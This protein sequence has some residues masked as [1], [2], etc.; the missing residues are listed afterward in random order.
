MKPTKTAKSLGV[1]F[2]L[3]AFAL[4]SACSD[5]GPSQAEAPEQEAPEVTQEQET[6]AETQ[7]EELSGAELAFYN[8][9]T[10]QDQQITP[11]EAEANLGISSEFALIDLDSDGGINLSEFMDY[12]GEATAAGAEAESTEETVEQATE[13]LQPAEGEEQ[14]TQ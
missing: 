13:E 11:D 7:N 1:L 12:A 10:N 14:Q 9:D 8:L 6:A 5:Q 3:A 4:L 2:G